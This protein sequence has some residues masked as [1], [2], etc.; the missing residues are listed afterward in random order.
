MHV[1]PGRHIEPRLPQ[2]FADVE[3]TQAP[4]ASQHPAQLDAEQLAGAGP[5][6]DTVAHATPMMNP[7]TPK[8][9]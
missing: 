7:T 5:H 4:D 9:R 3:V 8:D 2:A 1:W 6:D